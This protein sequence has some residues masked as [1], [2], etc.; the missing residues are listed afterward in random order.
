[1]GPAAVQNGHGPS[2]GMPSTGAQSGG[3]ER[4]Q[5][6]PDD[7]MLSTVLHRMLYQSNADIHALTEAYVESTRSVL[8]V[9]PSSISFVPCP[10]LVR[11]AVVL[12]CCVLCLAV[13]LVYLRRLVGAMQWNLPSKM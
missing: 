11:Y 9:P 2:E 13:V 1:M 4:P 8:L 12:C 10:F 7:V 5:L 3:G 6:G